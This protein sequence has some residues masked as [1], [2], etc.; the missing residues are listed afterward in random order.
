MSDKISVPQS[1]KKHIRKRF[2]G[3]LPVV[4]DVETGGANAARDALLE[5]GAVLVDY[6]ADNRLVPTEEF[7][8]HVEAFEGANLDPAAMAVNKIDPHHPFRFAIG[9]LEA[10]TQLFDF[11]RDAVKKTQCRRAV[12]VGHNAHF[13]LSFIQAAAKRCKLHQSPLHRFT[14]FDTATLGA[15]FFG[16]SVLAKALKAAKIDFDKNEAHSALYDAQKTAELFCQAINDLD[17]N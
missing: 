14:V 8:C 11:I 3:F 12:L 2:D 6:D 15:L 17:K 13:D 7:S 1:G 5:I 10:M 9:E 4:I 16:K